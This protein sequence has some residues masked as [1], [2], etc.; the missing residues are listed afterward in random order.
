MDCEYS[1]PSAIFTIWLTSAVV[2]TVAVVGIAV[3]F[4]LVSFV[5]SLLRPSREN[6]T[7]REL[8]ARY[9]RERAESDSR[10][11][12]EV[13]NE[14]L[15]RQKRQERQIRERWHASQRAEET[16]KRRKEEEDAARIAMTL[17]TATREQERHRAR[18]KQEEDAARTAMTLAAT[19]H[20]QQRQADEAAKLRR[21]EERRAEE[22]TRMAEESRRQQEEAAPMAIEWSGQSAS[23]DRRSENTNN[24]IQPTEWPTAQEY[25]DAK[26][27]TQY[28][29]THFS[30]A[31][32]GIAGSGKSSLINVF[33]DL[34]DDDPNAAP[35]GV[36]ETTSEI[37]RYPDPG[38]QP[39]RKWTVWYDIPGAGTLNIPG[40]RYFNQQCLFV[41][42]LIIV[43]VG[44]RMTQ[45]DLEILKNCRLFKIPTFIVRSKADM[46][47]RNTMRAKGYES[48][49]NGR[50][51]LRQDCSRDFIRKTRQSIA[52][53]LRK[54]GLPPQ[55]VYIV[56]CSRAFRAEYSAFTSGE[57]LS[58][59]AARG[60]SQFV[61][62]KQLIHD[63]MHAAVSRRCDVN[64]SPRQEPARREV[65][66]AG[67]NILGVLTD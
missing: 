23:R 44:D 24:G 29:P 13:T 46:H 36:V 40:W 48:G 3:V 50:E 12:R 4:G 53:Q 14:M 57:K 67:L 37:R 49:D 47:I 39:P 20:I 66:P 63:L 1:F 33:L 45:V 64:S 28:S 16:R 41:F 56:S 8:E 55:R 26:V 18:R 65:F 7:M 25:F 43:L 9:E 10:R 17:M 22:E 30:F 59:D 60:T 6:D 27:K 58:A 52:D 11:Q 62:E 32:A 31:V 21:N 5:A 61:D 35:T 2:A 34:A 15:E 54:A 51:D 19:T 42:D 38:D